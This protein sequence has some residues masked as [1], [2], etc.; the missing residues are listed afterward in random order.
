MFR[1]VPQAVSSY[2]VDTSLDERQ[3][4][5][6]DRLLTAANEAIGLAILTLED[7][8]NEDLSRSERHERAATARQ[9][10]VEA[11]TA[12]SRA[13]V[14]IP[15]VR[16]YTV[17]VI[18]TAETSIDAELG[19]LHQLAVRMLW[20]N[21][22]LFPKRI[23]GDLNAEDEAQLAVFCNA[24][25]RNARIDRLMEY[26][27]IVISVV[28]AGLGPLLG[29]PLISAYMFVVATGLTAVHL[30]RAARRAATFG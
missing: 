6:A 26:R 30:A 13:R 25:A 18:T 7:G 24:L 17:A 3:R 29:A 11:V 15:A 23:R 9:F 20:H 28:L 27:W 21:H 16:T 19:R 1:Y 14:L 8:S 22:N 12:L 2:R 5:L 10:L 4:E